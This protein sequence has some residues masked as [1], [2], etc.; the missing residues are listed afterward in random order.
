MKR[1]GHGQRSRR[2]RYARDRFVLSERGVQ[3]VVIFLEPVE[4]CGDSVRP[5]LQ[6][7]PIKP[8]DNLVFGHTDM[9]GNSADDYAFSKQPPNGLLQFRRPR[10]PGMA[11]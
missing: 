5:A 10:R 6:V 2:W 7:M 1:T 3:L 11:R 9:A 4:G 8:T